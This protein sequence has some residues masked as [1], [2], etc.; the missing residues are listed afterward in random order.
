V[1]LAFVSVIYSQTT[2]VP[3]FCPAAVANPVLAT[4]YINKLLAAAGANQNVAK[5]LQ[6][7]ITYVTTNEGEL[8][9]SVQT[10]Q[11]FFLGLP[12]P[13]QA[14]LQATGLSPAAAKLLLILYIDNIIITI[15]AN[16]G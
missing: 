9:T 6:Q 16:Q 11:Q 4:N 2:T 3:R 13:L 7:T 10:C 15:L 14:D 1:L 8:T 5:V 12:T